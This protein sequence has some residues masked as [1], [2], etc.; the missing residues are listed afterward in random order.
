M[1]TMQEYADMY[2][3]QHRGK[4]YY[5]DLTDYSFKWTTLPTKENEKPT[6]CIFMKSYFW[7]RQR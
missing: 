7:E 3:K 5:S 1:K 4:G 6:T 2:Q